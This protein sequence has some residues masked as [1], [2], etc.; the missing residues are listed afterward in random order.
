MVGDRRPDRSAR[1]ISEFHQADLIHRWRGSTPAPLIRDRWI[2]DPEVQNHA[3][4][5]AQPFVFLI[6]NL[7]PVVKLF[8]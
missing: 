7:E 6:C 8:T 2:I 4:I 1:S 3:M 5:G